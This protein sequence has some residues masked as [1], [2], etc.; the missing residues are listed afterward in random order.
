MLR[1]P[2]HD[3]VVVGYMEQLYFVVLW[4]FARLRR[5]PLV[6]DAFLLFYGIVTR[7]QSQNRMSVTH[8]IPPRTGAG[9]GRKT[10]GVTLGVDDHALVESCR[11][12]EQLRQRLGRAANAASAADVFAG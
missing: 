2:R 12:A 4:P 6:R 8:K 5:T 9:T 3:A 11:D 1:M 7:T 10:R